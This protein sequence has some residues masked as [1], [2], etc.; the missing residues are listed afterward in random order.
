MSRL[1]LEER[2]AIFMDLL[3]AISLF[4]VLLSGT[5]VA[6][7]NFERNN[8][9][10][11]LQNDAQDR[12]RFAIDGLAKMLRND[13]IEKAQPFD[14]V[15]QQVNGALPVSGNARR[16]ER[17][18]YCLDTSNSQNAVLWRQVQTWT[19]PPTPDMAGTSTCPSEDPLWTDQDVVADHVTNGN[20]PVFLYDTSVPADVREV[21][22]EL[23]VDFETGVE[24]AE[25]R[26][27]S[28]VYLRNRNR[29]P[30]AAMSAPVVGTRGG[31]YYIYLNGSASR[32]PDGD[33]LTYVWLANG[34]PISASSLKGTG[35]AVAYG[36]VSSGTSHSISLRVLDPAELEHTSAA[37][38]VTVP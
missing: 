14:L 29:A 21:R 18:R 11:Q 19:E 27:T 12:A 37:Q 3:V 31:A 36:P 22:A 26:L 1:L 33:H 4:I 7:N 6:Y 24:P 9:S 10:N 15:G 30:T 16:R 2:G 23:F 20:R 38:G 34:N 25:S 5:L 13:W 28:G 35:P 8:R 17:V 32:D